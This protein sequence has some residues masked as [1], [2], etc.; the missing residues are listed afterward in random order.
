MH[1]ENSILMQAPVDQVFATAADLSRWPLFLP[2]YRWVRY[3]KRSPQRNIVTMAARCKRIRIHWTSEQVVDTAAREV[4]FRHLKAFTRGM[5]VVW[6]FTATP[7]GV[8]VR[9]R[10]DL[11]PSIPIVGRLI[12]DII[13]GRFFI[14]PVATQTLKH[15]K[16]F[17]EQ[18]REL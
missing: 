11:A 12:T 17:V 2:H 4:R 15:M 6:T 7:D 1:A 5:V 14:H 13:I 10:H 16:R 9:I 18:T 3:H 8:L